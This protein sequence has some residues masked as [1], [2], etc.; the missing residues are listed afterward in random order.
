MRSNLRASKSPFAVV[1][2]ASIFAVPLSL[3]IALTTGSGAEAAPVK[4]LR[5]E[6]TVS[7]PTQPVAEE[8]EKKYVLSIPNSQARLFQMKENIVRTSVGDPGIVEPVVIGPH[9]LYIRGKRPGETTLALWDETDAVLLMDVRVESGNGIKLVASTAREKKCDKHLSGESPVSAASENNLRL[10][11]CSSVKR[12]HLKKSLTDLLSEKPNPRR[13]QKPLPREDV[14]RWGDGE[15]DK[16]IIRSGYSGKD[17]KPTRTVDVSTSKMR[18]FQVPAGIKDITACDPKITE[19]VVVEK[20]RFV[21]LGKH[22]GTATLAFNDELGNSE[23]WKIRVDNTG[24]PV[25]RTIVAVRNFFNRAF[26]LHHEQPFPLVKAKTMTL[27]ELGTP[28]GLDVLSGQS[29]LFKTENSIVRTAVSDPTIA[30][31]LVVSST[32]LALTGQ[33]PGRTTMFVWD[34]RENV[35]S[36][37]VDVTNGSAPIEKIASDTEP[38]LTVDEEVYPREI[39]AW[40][41]SAKDVALV[42]DTSAEVPKSTTSLLPVTYLRALRPLKHPCRMGAIELNNQ[43][44]CLLESRDYERA[45][46]TLQNA[47][48]MDPSYK[49]AF[50][51]IAIAYNNLGLSQRKNPPLAIRSFHKAWYLDPDNQVTIKNL[52]IMLRVAGRDVTNFDD[53]VALGDKAREERDIAGSIMEYK[54]ALQIREDK[55]VRAKL[56]EVLNEL[57]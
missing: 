1:F 24:N 20:R 10:E 22:A 25:N 5:V 54:A 27:S 26:L 41:G 50:S 48:I 21:L 7:A 45:I 14:L 49:T 12:A 28:K 47:I 32:E 44:V 4:E 34:N 40:F 19:P 31:P 42:P 52:N 30:L 17:Y 43:A 57:N 11:E 33:S 38:S 3:T 46:M 53:R 13:P 2:A 8:F 51:N 29:R 6:K 16:A 37:T 18:V 56:E 35:S 39:E 23:A 36:F 55:D 9:E 15:K